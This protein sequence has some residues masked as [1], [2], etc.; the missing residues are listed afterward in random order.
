MASGRNGLKRRHAT[1]LYN[2]A[3]L[4]REDLRSLFVARHAE[5]DE[6]LGHLR[7]AGSSPQHSLVLGERGMGKTTL[8]L[9]LAHSVEEEPDL[10]RQWL[11]VRFDEEQYNIGELAD[12]WLNCL[13][14]IGEDTGDT[15]PLEIVDRLIREY[16]DRDKSQKEK[17]DPLEEA[18]FLRL[19][20]Y[21]VQHERRLLLLVDNLDLLLARLDPKLEAHRLREVLQQETWLMLVGAS[22]RPI[23]ETFNY[24]SPFYD[25]FRVIPL[26][27]LSFEETLDFL[28]KLGACF[29]RE[30][31]TADVIEQRREDLSILHT[32]MGGNLR[33][34]TLLFS[35]LH[36]D[37][38]AELEF[39][40]ER[41]LD[42]YTSSYKDSI[43]ALPPQGQRV[44]DALARSWNPAT[45]EEIARDL[46]IER[47]VASAQL[48]RL[49]DRDLAV[50]VQL[51]RRSLGFQIRDRLFNLWYLMRGGRRQRPHLRALL[52]F[53]GL[54]YRR[55]RPA[56][57]EPILGRLQRLGLLT[58]E[59]LADAEKLAARLAEQEGRT[60][61][62]LFANVRT[63]LLAL[64]LRGQSQGAE[65]Q[66]R[67]VL[68]Y[69]PGDELVR[70]LYVGLLERQGR[71]SE[72]LKVLYET[73]GVDQP[74]WLRLESARLSV[75]LDGT[76]VDVSLLMSLLDTDVPVGEVAALAKNLAR[77]GEE[78]LVWAAQ[79]LLSHALKLA[80]AELDVLLAGCEVELSLDRPK[81]ALTH[82][83]GAFEAARRA[84]TLAE[85]STL[86]DVALR[87]GAD[88]PRETLEVLEGVGLAE[89]WLPMTHALAFLGGQSD[90]LE[91]LS[92]EMRTF[93]ESVIGAI[94]G[95]ERSIPTLV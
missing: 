91:K 11:A 85:S 41:L 67:E 78:R 37:P 56:E 93:T 58:L 66:S 54:F 5:R 39:L 82:L 4:S 74:A 75:A 14:K 21:A 27:P 57:P 10:F 43:E 38:S 7:A 33:T 87:L 76:E 17:N 72:A 51:P 86:L 49:V 47:G 68:G 46:R 20:Q 55:G 16:P 28:K 6:I 95:V 31:D 2:P 65:S 15:K 18:A 32:L 26:A 50:K 30:K 3:L 92:P 61:G 44:F 40:L 79:G 48:H 89:D 70:A 22:T 25:L 9:R 36:E 63:H 90:R 35:N 60:Q 77:R 84:G 45:A 69:N 62:E 73:P 23:L 8:L 13:E 1:F 29:H 53:L 52:A 81:Q 12:F 19:R 71:T 34:I 80:P 42:Q 88:H 83:R 59:L 94:Q 24:Y 64:C